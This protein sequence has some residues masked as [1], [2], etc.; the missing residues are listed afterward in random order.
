[1]PTLGRKTQAEFSSEFKA[2]LIYVASSRPAAA[3]THHHAQ[4]LLFITLVFLLSESGDMCIPQRTC[5]GQEV[6][7]SFHHVCSRD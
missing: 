5:E 7:V 3:S 2:N 4:L 1:M 6:V